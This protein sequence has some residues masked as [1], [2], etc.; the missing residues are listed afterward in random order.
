MQAVLFIGLAV[1]AAHGLLWTLVER[2]FGWRFG[3]GGGSS[4]PKGW[5]AVLLSATMTVPLIVLPALYG[6]LADTTILPP[7]HWVAGGCIVI[8]SAVG[9][10]LIYGA[11]AFHLAG[12]RNSVFPLNMRDWHRALL[13]ELVYALTHFSS[14]VL[15]YRFVTGWP[16]T[17]N[18][19]FPALLSG[20]VWFSST[21]IFIF[22]KYPDSLTDKKGIELRGVIHA[23]MLT[24]TLEGGMLM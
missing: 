11:K 3:A 12:W 18:V 5:A 20:S 22:V 2:V 15:L 16:M 23:I 13:M 1:A 17:A 6:R 10:V 7:S 19:I 9:H 4:L 24:I 21:C 14:I 8:F